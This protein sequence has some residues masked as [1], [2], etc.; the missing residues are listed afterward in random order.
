M[1]VI[2][3]KRGFHL[4]LEYFRKGAHEG[5]RSCESYE[6]PIFMTSNMVVIYITVKPYESLFNLHN[7]RANNS[8]SFPHYANNNTVD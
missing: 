5:A 4:S 1:C 6:Q 3:F 8:L 7:A 2:S